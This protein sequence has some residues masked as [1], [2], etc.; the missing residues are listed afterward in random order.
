MINIIKHIASKKPFQAQNRNRALLHKMRKLGFSEL[1]VRLAL[2][3]ANRISLTKIMTDNLKPPTL[4]RAIH[5]FS[6][7][8]EAQKHIAHKLGIEQSELWS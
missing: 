5:G 6:K 4:S 7:N 8:G 3:A 2:I 1:E